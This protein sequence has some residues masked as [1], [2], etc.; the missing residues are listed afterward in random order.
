VTLRRRLLAALASLALLFTLGAATAVPA[1]ASIE[2]TFKICNDHG[3]EYIE[4]HNG[5][6]SS[7]LLRPYYGDCTGWIAMAGTRVDTDP[8]GPSHSYRIN[9]GP[10]H[11]NSDNHDS[12]PPNTAGKIVN[13]R[14]YDHGDCTN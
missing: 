4:V 3:F 8:E 6:Y 5:G 11:T 12:D 10:C 9:G 1:Q 14:N 7:G 2:P 13:Y